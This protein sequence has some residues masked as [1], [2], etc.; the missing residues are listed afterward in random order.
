MTT[1]S[2]K[3]SPYL[4][5]VIVLF[6]AGLLVFLGVVANYVVNQ[7]PALTSTTIAQIFTGTSLP[8]F[9]PSST[10][11]I[12]LTPRPT[13]TLR[14]TST[15]ST[16]PTPPGTATSTLYPTL[17]PAMPAKVNVSYELKPWDLGEQERMVGL[18]HSNTILNP[19]ESAFRALAYAEGEGIIRFP[20]S[21]DVSQWRWDRAYNL[22][23]I[24]DPLGIELYADLIQSAI[25]SSQV[26]SSD[27]PSWFSLYETRL[28][29]EISPLPPQP[30]ELGREL[31][32]IRGP[33]SAFLWL[34]EN[35]GK[36]VIYPLLNDIDF[37]QPHE[38]AFLYGDLTGD[39]SPELVIYRQDTPG[40]TLLVPPHIFEVMISPPAELTSQ[41]QVPVDFGFEP[42]LQAELLAN[43]YNG[44]NLRLS[45][46]LSPACP[47]NLSQE[48]HWDGAEFVITPMQ[49]QLVPVADL[50]AFCQAVFD[51]A[52]S[53]WGPGPAITVA[54]AVLGVWPPATD[55]Q[56]HPYPPDA[57]DQLRYRLGIEYALASQAAE[58]TRVMAEIIDTPII[59]DSRWIAPAQDFLHIFQAPSDVYSACQV[60]Q[61]CNMRDAFQ[62]MVKYAA[63]NDFGQ[64]ILYLQSHAVTIRSS[65]LMDFDQNGQDERW[66]VI[67]P[68][69]GDKLEFWIL[70]HGQTQVRGVFVQVFE[71]GEALPFF[72]TPEGNVPVFQ[73]E[74]HSGYIFKY[75]PT[76]A[77]AYVQAVD[78]E[79]ARPTIIRDGYQQAV[80]DLMAGKDLQG[81][82][83]NLNSLFISPRF[84]G[85]CIAF[86]F[87]DQ[88][89]YTLALVDD[90]SGHADDA[91]DQYLWVWRNYGKSPLAIMS[92]L[93]LNY[94]PLPTYTRTPIPTRTTAPTRTATPTPTATST[95][96]ATLTFT[97]TSTS[98]PT[99]TMT[100]TPTSTPTPTESA[101]LTLPSLRISE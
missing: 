51:Q 47:A 78:V 19:S 83:A 12:T 90:I 77:T 23:R 10:S 15:A 22:V 97:P 39:A 56:G 69:P 66:L 65:G 73:F 16:T 37:N 5:P 82:L 91:I 93:K 64:V 86:N 14:P 30:G 3:H 20:D 87:C 68:K 67:Q 79:Y 2:P 85:D 50:T 33:G 92:R 46:M 24:N 7:E 42:R 75:L 6:V 62:T 95:P 18:M 59:T 25:A 55:T 44:S 54:N 74:L 26:R 43:A 45:F 52:S 31:V 98:T 71:V 101:T 57:F 9:T 70:Y 35:P 60:A 41:G 61:Y 53:T 36:T 96:S 94:F 99:T 40:S 29:L 76:S 100:F 34:V 84:A 4:I 8:T 72:Y 27:L 48:Y 1:G 11:T 80:N 58:A 49:Y 21:L 13:W 88:F 28:T 63:S 38:N 89:H 81:I 17:T 32:A